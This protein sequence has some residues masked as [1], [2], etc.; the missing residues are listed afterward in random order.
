MKSPTCK[1]QHPTWIMMRGEG[2]YLLAIGE[3]KESPKG[4]VKL[5]GRYFLL[6]G[7]PGTNPVPSNDWRESALA[8]HTRPTEEA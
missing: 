5:D 3:T 6:S 8:R 7:R 4:G 1:C 2:I